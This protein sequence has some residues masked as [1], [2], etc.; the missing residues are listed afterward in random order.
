MAPDQEGL[1]MFTRENSPSWICAVFAL[2]Q[3]VQQYVWRSEDLN[4]PL[5][6]AHTVRFW[7]S[8][9]LMIGAFTIKV[10]GKFF[11]YPVKL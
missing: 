5:P 6:D 1:P 4:H 9:L 3:V 11:F 8:N 7:A 2:L 10:D